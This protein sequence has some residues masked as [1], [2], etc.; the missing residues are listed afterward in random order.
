MTTVCPLTDSLSLDLELMGSIGLVSVSGNRASKLPDFTALSKE[1]ALATPSLT[2]KDSYTPSNTVAQACPATG[3]DWAAS[4]NLP[5][6]IDYGLCSCLL[7]SLSCVAS[8]GLSGEQIGSLFSTVCSMDSKACE[9]ISTNAAAGI[10]GPFSMCDAHTKLSFAMHQYYVDQN[11]V[12]TACD[13]KGNAKL[14]SPSPS[15]SCSAILNN[16]GFTPARVTQQG[17]HTKK[18]AAGMVL[19]PRSGVGLLELGASLMIAGLAGVVLVLL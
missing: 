12:P 7:S 19:V 10:Y 15:P 18:S 16:A 2:S 14:Q 8:K 6:A 11:Q 3:A 4:S 17:G 1:L 13:F 9:G 5:P